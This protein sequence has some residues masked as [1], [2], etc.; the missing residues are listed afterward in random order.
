MGQ[1]HDIKEK[2]EST[3]MNKWII[4]TYKNLWERDETVLREKFITLVHT[5]RSRKILKSVI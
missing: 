2:N 5:L 3:W 1:R 4:A